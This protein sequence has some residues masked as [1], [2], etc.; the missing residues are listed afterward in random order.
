MR[1]LQELGQLTHM[2]ETS[3]P[4]EVDACDLDVAITMINLSSEWGWGMVIMSEQM[5]DLSSEMETK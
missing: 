3:Q 2:Q 5:G 1:R 4:T